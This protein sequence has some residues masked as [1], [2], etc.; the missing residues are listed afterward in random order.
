[1]VE[2]TPEENKKYGCPIKL[3]QK[4]TGGKWKMFIMWLL[5]GGKKRF[6]ELSRSLT[7]ITQSQLTKALRELEHDGFL[8]RH[9]FQEVPPKVEYSLS[10]LGQSFIPIL[11]D[12]YLWGKNH[13]AYTDLDA[14]SHQT[15]NQN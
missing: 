10:E 11:E 9:V 4:A 7:P 6:G 14:E 13:L 1:M 15:D 5:R 2:F 12:M 8:I 3:L